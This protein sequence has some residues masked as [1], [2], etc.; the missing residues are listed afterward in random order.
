MA[1]FHQYNFHKCSQFL[2][3]LND[4]TSRGP[5]DGNQIYAGIAYF[6]IALYP[7]HAAGGSIIILN[8]LDVVLVKH[9]N[10]TTLL[11]SPGY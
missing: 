7:L 6:D 9:Y 11:T 10:T 8:H 5:I 3:K 1:W 4:T 2:T